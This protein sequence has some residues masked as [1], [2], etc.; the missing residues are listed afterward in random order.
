MPR[1]EFFLGSNSNVR[2]NAFS[3]EVVTSPITVPSTG[4]NVTGSISGE[5]SNQRPVRI[6]RFE[7]YFATG[8]GGTIRLRLPNNAASTDG[9]ADSTTTT[10]SGARRDFPN[11]PKF[12]GDTFHYGFSKG[13]ATNSRIVCGPPGVLNQL[14]GT[15]AVSN[16]QMY[17]AFRVDTVPSAPRSFTGA[18]SGPNSVFLSWSSP[19]DTATLPIIGYRVLYRRTSSS[20]WSYGGNT[21][22]TSLTVTGLL[23]NTSYEFA[24]AAH[25]AV[26]QAHGGS[27]SSVNYHTGTNAKITRTT[28]NDLQPA[29]ASITADSAT[30]TTIRV[31]WNTT[32]DPTFVSVSGPGITTSNQPSGD[33]TATGL[34]PNRTYTYEITARNSANTVDA[35]DSS[36]AR[37]LL[38]TPTAN[39]EAE[40]INARSA[41]V[42]WST[43][44]ATTVTVSGTNLSSSD[45]SGNVIVDG[46]E[47]GGI[48]RWSIEASNADASVGPIE[49]A[50]IQLPNVVGGV[51]NGA[52]W[53]I[54]TL[55]VWN[56]SSW[57]TG[58]AR[59]W[60]GTQWKIW[61]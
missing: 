44:D 38:P 35:T 13:D 25:N 36:S 34:S 53:A 55:K 19:S 43:S 37:T 41:R 39:I 45:P 2:D 50:S 59:V 42:I 9:Y 23:A 11:I 56:G 1:N 40:A 54:P 22:G 16:R 48:Y 7:I 57:V 29:T 12:T 27:V 30:Q 18:A 4:M 26:S 28:E 5:S 60:T 8:S 21:T 3:S 52:E 58:E 31:R 46:L 17:A 24:V 14:R 6:S 20:S 61:V 51:W 33:V 10:A 47:P 15:S 49:S 32:N